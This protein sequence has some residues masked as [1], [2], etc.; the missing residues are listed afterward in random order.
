MEP[1]L[2]GSEPWRR[3]VEKSKRFNFEKRPRE[4]G[5]VPVRRFSSNDKKASWFRLPIE[6]GMGPG[7]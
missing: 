5:R 3:L 2:C 1:R 4:D 6:L 7:M